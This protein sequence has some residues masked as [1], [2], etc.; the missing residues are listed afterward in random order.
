MRKMLISM[1]ISITSLFAE[2][3]PQ[4]VGTL[5][6]DLEFSNFFKS[7]EVLPELKTCKPSGSDDGLFG[8]IVRHT[9]IFLFTETVREKGYLMMIDT[10]IKGKSGGKTSLIDSFGD[11]GE[12]GSQ[13]VNL[14]E[15]PVLA[16]IGKKIDSG[17]FF[18]FHPTT[19]SSFYF[20]FLDPSAVD[21]I[22]VK[23][24][25]D[26]VQSLTVTGMIASALDCLAATTLDA[27]PFGSKY[28]AIGKVAFRAID[29]F[30]YSTGC[31]GIVSVGPT[32]Q[33][34]SPL[35]NGRLIGFTQL[36]ERSYYSLVKQTKRSVL[37]KGS[38]V[39]CSSKVGPLI[40]SQFISQ[41]IRPVPGKM[42]EVGATPAAWGTFKNDGSTAGDTVFAWW[43]RRE[44]VGFAHSCSW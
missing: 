43:M 2:A 33:S 21:Y 32:N 30:T 28:N 8:V 35:V 1:A 18:C 36:K 23:M 11:N 27:V 24:M 19:A 12:E 7:M 16:L 4:W 29:F 38:D 10:N 34:E 6:E 39:E 31:N 40:K 37:N 42:Y 9:D 3:D 13:Y 20:S 17:G 22:K 26:V 41:L 25:V 14:I 15:L 5:A 44:I